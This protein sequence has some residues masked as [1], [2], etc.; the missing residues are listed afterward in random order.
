MK[1]QKEFGDFQTPISLCHDVVRLID[2]LGFIP[3]TVVEPTAGAGAFLEAAQARWGSS[4]TYRGFEI[5]PAYLAAHQPRLRVLGIDLAEADFFQ[6][7][8]SRQLAGRVLVLGNPPWVTNAALGRDGGRNLPVKSNLQGL[9]GIE[10]KTGKANFDIAEWMLIRLMESLPPQGMLAM[11]C[12]TMTARK[13]LRHLWRQQDVEGSIYRIDARRE[14]GVTVEACLLVMRAASSPSRS[15]FSYPGLSRDGAPLEFGLLNGRMVYDLAAAR[16]WSGLESGQPIPW[17]SGVKH[18]AAKVMELDANFTNDFGETVDVEPERVFPLLKCT[19]LAHGSAPRRWLILPQF[20][21]A[22]ATAK[23]RE[24]APKL[25]RYLESHAERLS[26]R[27]SSIYRNRPPFS[28]FGVGDYSFS[29]WK[30]GVSALHKQP[31]FRVIGPIG[32][33][34]VM[35]DD[36]GC[37]LPCQTRDE[38]EDIAARMNSEAYQRYLS[39]LAMPEAKRPVTIELLRRIRVT[40]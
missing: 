8:W 38:A 31:R 37:F 18:D 23:L 11:L 13:V 34:P 9:R 6:V 36:T 1:H 33:R 30:V 27:K 21:P 3:E 32:S 15:G 4:A 20:H 17:R 29:H 12:K 39:C 14:F 28:V 19:D 25:W 22:E 7:D 16:K 26:A 2:G 35:L 10:A 24:S 40:E 5:N